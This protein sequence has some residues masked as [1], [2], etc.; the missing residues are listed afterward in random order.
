MLETGQKSQAL[1]CLKRARTAF[2]T[3]RPE[4]TKRWKWNP[5]RGGSGAGKWGREVYRKVEFWKHGIDSE[6]GWVD[7]AR[8]SILPGF[9][10]S[11]SSASKDT[12]ISG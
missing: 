5:H 1:S 2:H 7:P 8:I 12:L 3:D 6:K 11:P 4:G 10:A 9:G